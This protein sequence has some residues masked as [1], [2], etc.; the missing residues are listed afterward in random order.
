MD[1]GRYGRGLASAVLYR[2]D[3]L[4]LRVQVGLQS[5]LGIAGHYQPNPFA[6]DSDPRD[7][8]ACPE[9]FEAF[10]K[11]LPA[12]ALSC[13]D[14]GCNIGYFTFRMAQRGG[15][16][17]GIDTGRNEISYARGLAALHGVRNAAFLQFEISA[18]SIAALPRADVIICMSVF[19]HWVRKLGLEEATR[20]VDGMARRC[21]FL[22]FETGQHDETDTSWARHLSFMGEDCDS[23]IRDFLVARGFQS[24]ELM[25][26]FSTTLSAVPRHLYLAQMQ[27][28]P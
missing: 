7:R 13:I 24:V 16:C 14:I 6:V 4:W 5:V 21:S 11:A 2:L 12:G 25:G 1:I 19:H 22:V 3:R 26:D 23:W 10:S 18:D 9:R 20:I 27:P 28:R 8:R 17:L 15:I